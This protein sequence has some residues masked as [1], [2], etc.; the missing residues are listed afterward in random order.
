MILLSCLLGML[1]MAGLGWLRG[2]IT[3]AQTLLALLLSGLLAMP[4]GLLGRPVARALGTPELLVP[5]MGSLLTGLCIFLVL[6]AGFSFYLKKRFENREPPDWD[7]PIGAMVG[8][9]W[10]LLLILILLTGLNSVARADRAMR[11]A[12]AVNQLRTQ[13][14]KKVELQV[15]RELAPDRSLYEEEEFARIATVTVAKRMKSYRVDPA[16]VEELVEPSPLDGLIERL[17]NSPLESAV[18]RF[19]AVDA[20]TETVLRDLAIVVGDPI[21]FDR[22]QHHKTIR[23][24]A[25]DRTIQALGNDLEISSAIG[26]KRFRD[27]LNH[28]RIVELAGDQRLRRK[29]KNVDVGEILKGVI[30]E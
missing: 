6:L 13:E 16:K 29:L 18:E 30:G 28:P 15:N 1:A 11:E 7:K 24:L 21:L 12:A 26:E 27:L 9:V 14:R 3:A 17:E 10:G 19:S 23:E 22:F 5:M 8:A 2:A 4:L 20:K 25:E